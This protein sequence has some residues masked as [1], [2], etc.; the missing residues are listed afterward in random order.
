MAQ[1]HAHAIGLSA[2]LLAS[3]AAAD[4]L[5]DFGGRAASEANRIL[6]LAGM[7]PTAFETTAETFSVPGGT[8]VVDLEFHFLQQSGG[9]KFSFGIYD[10]RNV[11]ADPALERDLYAQQ[12]ITTGTLLFQEGRKAQN[13]E[14]KPGAKKTISVV[15]GAVLGLF[16]LPNYKLDDYLNDPN[17]YS[18]AGNKLPPLFSVSAANPGGY[19]QVLSFSDGTQT[20]FTFEDIMRTSNSD[21]DFNDATVV[22]N[23]DLRDNQIGPTVVMLAPGM[24]P[25]A[26][27][28]V[29]FGAAV[30]A[31]RRYRAQP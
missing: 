7:T 24:V 13:N 30:F 29:G 31:F 26:A 8:G 15:A 18:E 12:A 10:V 11:T 4:A 27:G 20:L 16:F 21:E 19:D 23:A 2:F 22:V 14:Q 6:G 17:D 28:A 1:V 3:P 5:A 25:I 9:Y